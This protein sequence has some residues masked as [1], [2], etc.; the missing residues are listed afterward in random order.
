M[1]HQWWKIGCACPKCGKS[2]QVM[3]AAHSSDGQF[4]FTLV[5]DDDALMIQ[6]E[7]YAS[8]LQDIA[9]DNDLEN[10]QKEEQE[11]NGQH[12]NKKQKFRGHLTPPLAKPARPAEPLTDRDKKF[13]K[14]SGIESGSG[15]ES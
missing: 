7:P 5:C 10:A 1:K 9:R 8:K 4:Q 3:E 2:M 15:A 11:R 13:L 12:E 14:D 6:W